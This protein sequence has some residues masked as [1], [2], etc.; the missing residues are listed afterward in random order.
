MK[1]YKYVLPIILGIMIISGCSKS[2]SPGMSDEEKLAAAWENFTNGDYEKAIEYFTEL[3]DDEEY[4]AEAY[5]GLGWSNSF[6][7]QLQTAITNFTN[8][9]N[10]NPTIEIE[11]DIYAGRSFA[12]EAL[13]SYEDCLLDTDQIDEGWEFLHKDD[14]SYNDII[15]LRAICYYALGEFENSLIEVQRLDPG[16]YAD[17]STEEGR[18]ALAAKIEELRGIV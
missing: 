12:Y 4:L 7:G 5:S 8:G 14:L 2:S 1:T 15:L 9:L 18:A 16:F 13:S 10:N 11:D 17:V 3:I 6:L